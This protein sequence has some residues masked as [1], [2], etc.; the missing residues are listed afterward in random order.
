MPSDLG[1]ESF[2]L[3]PA[4]RTTSPRADSGPQAWVGGWGPVEI[5]PTLPRGGGGV[6]QFVGAGHSRAVRSGLRAQGAPGRRESSLLAGAGVE[7]EV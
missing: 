2:V 6:S 7:V 5:C 4:P 3:P 1:W